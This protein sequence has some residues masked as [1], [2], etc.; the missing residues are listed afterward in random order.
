MPKHS[1]PWRVAVGRCRHIPGPR[2]SL[3]EARFCDVP[4][5]DL[6][7]GTI[8]HLSGL[9]NMFYVNFKVHDAMKF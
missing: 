6:N 1:C 9:R 3:E 7:V 4:H 2:L 5:V 8:S